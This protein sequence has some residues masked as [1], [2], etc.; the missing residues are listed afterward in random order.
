M[1]LDIDVRLFSS[2]PSSNLNLRESPQATKIVMSPGETIT[3][4]GGYMRGHGTYLE[5]E[6]GL[7]S[8]VAGVVEKVNKLIT[9]RPLKTRYNP[10]VGDVVVGRIVQV[11]QK[12]W[13]VDVG[14]RLHAALH[15]HSVNLPGGELRRKSIEDELMMSQYFIDGDLVSAEVQNVGVDGAVSLHTRNLKYGKLGQGALVT[16]SPSL[17]KRCKTHLHNLANGVHLIIGLNGFIWVTPDT[18]VDSSKFT[19]NHEQVAFP[20]REAICRT[21]NVI[22]CLAIHNIMLYDTSIVHAYDISREYSIAQLLKPEVQL[23][24]AQ[25]TRH[26]I[27]MEIS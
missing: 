9:V 1:A 4:D 10:E 20:L 18:E 27:Q 16:V 25:L 23:E 22:L 8:A 5:E 3:T 19:Q 15:L 26:K 6:S 12:L 2:R 13:K 14:A 17:I 7:L 11:C 24:V 21:R